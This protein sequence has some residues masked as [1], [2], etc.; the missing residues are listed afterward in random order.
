[1]IFF[2]APEI[3]HIAYYFDVQM[4]RFKALSIFFNAQIN[5]TYIWSLS[6]MNIE[7][8]SYIIAVLFTCAQFN[9]FGRGSVFAHFERVHR[10]SRINRIDPRRTL[11]HKWAMKI[12]EFPSW[13]IYHIRLRICTL[14]FM[15][16]F[17][18]KK[19]KFDYWKW[20]ESNGKRI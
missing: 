13:I 4:I 14:N 11:P 8:V 2:I 16:I 3:M 1:M 6:V 17:C 7:S 5:C 15:K 10:Q 20:N 9:P 12:D 18:E 19:D